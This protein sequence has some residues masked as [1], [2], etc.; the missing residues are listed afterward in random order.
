MADIVISA[1]RFP[2]DFTA[3]FLV[4]AGI[5]DKHEDFHLNFFNI[6]ARK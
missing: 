1:Q 2:K 5:F 6:K 3:K 4:G